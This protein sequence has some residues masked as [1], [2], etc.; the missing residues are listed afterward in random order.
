MGKR[1][2]YLFLLILLV[3]VDTRTEAGEEI[4]HTGTFY[5][6][7]V[8]LKIHPRVLSLDLSS[9][10][11]ESLN[12]YYSSLEY[13]G[14]KK[15]LPILRRYIDLF[16][17]DGLGVVQLVKQMSSQLLYGERF[18][19]QS[20]LQY[21]LLTELGY[22][23]LLTR[24]DQNLH[25]FGN[26][27]FETV[28][29]TYIRYNEKL[30]THLNF[31]KNKTYG[32]HFIYDG[33]GREGGSAITRN[34]SK[35]P[36]LFNQVVNKHFSVTYGMEKEVYQATINKSIANYLSD[37][38]LFEIGENYT[39]MGGS[40]QLKSS[41]VHSLK[42]R[43]VDL[44]PSDQVK[45]ILAFVQQCLPYATDDDLYGGEK[46]CFPEETLLA[47]AADCEDKVFLL[48]YLLK[49]VINVNSAAV[50]YKLDKHLSLAIEVPNNATYYNFA[51]NGKK[52]LM[53]EPTASYPHLGRPAFALNRIHA[54][55]EL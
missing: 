28:R 2:T 13:T 52:Y 26:L 10:D 47:Q 27:A 25:C 21:Y 43:V 23:V 39:K 44:P 40:D 18:N 4:L 48:S 7:S 3:S 45:Y 24:T 5:G 15:N 14:A 53:C 20:A 22:D 19:Q 30:Y 32:E 6:H 34:P 38:P 41:L 49:E 42:H 11:N 9:G 36:N 46:Y 29:K 54:V 31:R 37:L 16:E 1:L 51:S 12:R 35:L 8:P 33:W 50:Y 17:L 55:Y